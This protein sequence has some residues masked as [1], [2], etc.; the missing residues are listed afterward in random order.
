MKALKCYDKEGTISRNA[1]TSVVTSRTILPF[2]GGGTSCNF[3]N[4]C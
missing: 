1:V 2:V 3:K 4:V